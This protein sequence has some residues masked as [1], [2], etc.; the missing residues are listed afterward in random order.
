MRHRRA[1]NPLGRKRAHRSAML[2]HLASSLVMH[3]RVHTTVAKA[4]E[5]RG[6][7][8]PVLTKSKTDST[9]ARRYAFRYLRDKEAV[10]KLFAEVADKISNRPGG[11]MRILKEGYRAGDSAEMALVELVDFSEAFSAQQKAKQAKRTRRGGKKG[12]VKGG[13][14][15]GEAGAPAEK[16]EEKKEAEASS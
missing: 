3:K 12:P 16:Q 9:H 5:L 8:E 7:L 15:K 1:I 11:Y 10:K 14:S 6:Y 4:K 2:S 13:T